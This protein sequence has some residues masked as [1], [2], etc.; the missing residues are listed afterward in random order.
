[1]MITGCFACV[2]TSEK[3]FFVILSRDSGR[4]WDSIRYGPE[5][6]YFQDAQFPS[7]STW[8]MSGARDVSR[9]S[10]VQFK[11]SLAVDGFMLQ[12]CQTV[13]FLQAGAVF[14][15]HV[16]KFVTR[17]MRPYC[18]FFSYLID[19]VLAFFC[20]PYRLLPSISM[21]IQASSNCMWIELSILA[22]CSRTC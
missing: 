12:V 2:V 11:L 10:V 21:Y 14:V 20:F 4:T 3:Q 8:Y 6:N 17:S 9:G 19:I 22:P 1:M 15:F 16:L 7:L 13:S 18:A 5:V